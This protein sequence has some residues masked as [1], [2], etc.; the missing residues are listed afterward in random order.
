MRRYREHGSGKWVLEEVLDRDAGEIQ[1]LAVS[2]V[3]GLQFGQWFGHR[4][5]TGAGYRLNI[6]GLRTSRPQRGCEKSSVYYVRITKSS[7]LNL[8]DLCV[9]TSAGA[10]DAAVQRSDGS[11][12]WEF[13]R[14]LL[15]NRRHSLAAYIQAFLTFGRA[16]ML[17]SD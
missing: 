13:A 2:K 11:M 6:L 14:V 8:G 12:T 9:L 7:H 15:A 10:L 16:N 17:V 5:M 1:Y 3:T 4:F